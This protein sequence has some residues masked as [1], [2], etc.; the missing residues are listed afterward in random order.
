M[1]REKGSA[2]K[3]WFTEYP[4]P[5][6]EVLC[7]SV[8]SLPEWQNMGPPRSVGK[9]LSRLQS[10]CSKTWHLYAY[11]KCIS[12]PSVSGHFRAEST[13]WIHIFIACAL[14]SD[15]SFLFTFDVLCLVYTPPPFVHINSCLFAPHSA[16]FLIFMCTTFFVLHGS[17][18]LKFLQHQLA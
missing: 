13:L 8:T 9:S 3:V 12:P 10:C 11:S 1:I 14:F 4:L 18:K 17:L 5:C 7:G 16:E 6:S 2:L 15:Y